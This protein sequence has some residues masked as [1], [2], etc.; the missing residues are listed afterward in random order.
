MTARLEECV[1]ALRLLGDG[2]VGTQRMALRS[3]IS[4][5][6]DAE[7]TALEETNAQTRSALLAQVADAR[8]EVAL[9]RVALRKRAAEE[10]EELLPQREGD[11]TS[12]AAQVAHQINQSLRRTTAVV[13]EELARTDAAGHVR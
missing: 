5:A 3:V 6:D 8:E 9:A 10:R 2:D 7:L 1:N 4:A 11:N 13:S 12:T